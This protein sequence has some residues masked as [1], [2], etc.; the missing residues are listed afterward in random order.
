MTS[1][2][3]ESSNKSIFLADS[4]DP[5]SSSEAQESM[6][7]KPMKQQD[8]FFDSGSSRV[9]CGI[10][11]LPNDN[12][13]E[14]ARNLNIKLT[15]SPSIQITS[16]AGDMGAQFQTV[17]DEKIC[18]TDDEAVQV[19]RTPLCG[20]ETFNN[21]DRSATN[22]VHY[23]QEQ[24]QEP[25]RDYFNDEIT[26]FASYS[27]RNVPQDRKREMIR[28]ESERSFRI[29]DAPGYQ[30]EVPNYIGDDNRT[31]ITTKSAFSRAVLGMA[32]EENL[33][34]LLGMR[35]AH[36]PGNN[37]YQDWIQFIKNN[38]PFFGLCFHHRLHPI[39]VE[40]RIY[41]FI[42]S[43]SFGL[44]AT[45]SVYLYYMLSSENFDEKVFRIYV[46]VKEGAFQPLEISKGM[47]ALW[48]FNGIAHALFDLS[49]WH[50]SACNCF[51]KRRIFKRMQT[52]GKFA[53]VTISG[54]MAAISSCF[55]LYRAMIASA[56]AA[57]A[58]G[59]DM[60]EN[61]ENDLITDI[62]RIEG[63]TFL[64]GYFLE[65]L[66]VY[67]VVHPTLVTIM[68]SGALGCI[69][70]LGGRPAHI[71]REIH[72]LLNEREKMYVEFEIV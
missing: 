53:V 70:G 9:L 33:I 19:Q 18:E 10:S 38:H 64:L 59:G 37:W 24:H 54:I 41:I 44:F 72:R 25:S 2:E 20:I 71:N 55:I 51:S 65:L 6:S 35:S 15:S 17:T 45:N 60:D 50:M 26:S 68:F 57:A 42:A 69:P 1:S 56:L 30:R 32:E 22:E 67:V 8:P 11:S 12:D 39:R 3:N 13:E 52:L 5:Q 29:T 66:A 4:L 40:Q 43:V 23:T 63:Y 58:E 46:Q 36:L 61:E 16:S 62:F 47:V 48:A 7:D 14:L 27:K 21:D 49:L 31:Q 28:F 34:R